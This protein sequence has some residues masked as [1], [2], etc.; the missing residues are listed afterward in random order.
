[1]TFSEQWDDA[2]RRKMHQSVWPWSNLVSR[3]LRYTNLKLGKPDF[4]VLE[5]GCG[6]GANIPFMLEYKADYYG[7]DG[8]LATIE[9]L[10]E[11]FPELADRLAAGDFTERLN[12]TGPFDLVVDRAALT[13]ND[14]AAIRRCL[15]MVHEVLADGGMFIGCDWFSTES[16]RY[17]DGEQD[18]DEYTRTNITEG[19]FAGIGR[20][21]FADSEHIHDL[22]S[23][24]ELVALDHIVETTHI[25]AGES[26][27]TWQ[28][29]AVKR[30][31]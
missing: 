21:H 9:A 29:V 16:A 18:A 17:R 13:H 28:I 19:T 31:G 26:M 20:V 2:Y 4:R 27:A 3:C 14:T 6:A 7:Q 10:T 8:S 12:F 25:G 30:G 15:K 11:R 24:F 5:L 23:D 1:M 22:F